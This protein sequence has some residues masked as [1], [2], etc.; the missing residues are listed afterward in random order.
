MREVALCFSRDYEVPSA[1]NYL[2]HEPLFMAHSSG[3]E[4]SDVSSS[5]G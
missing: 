1:T 5:A 3:D 2:I 4:T